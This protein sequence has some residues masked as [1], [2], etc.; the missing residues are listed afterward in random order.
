[1]DI[2]FEI[3]EY[4][5]EWDEEKAKKNF[6]KHKIRFENAVLAFLDENKIDELD[7]LHSDFEDRYKIIGRVGK[8]LT[9]IYTERGDRNRIISARYATKKEVDDY[10]AG[11]YDA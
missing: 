11:N 2:Y 6:Q 1:M 10:Y 7:E 5:F 8:I 3:E 4:K 9:V